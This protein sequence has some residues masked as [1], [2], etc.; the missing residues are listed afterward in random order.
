MRSRKR[1][2][3]PLTLQAQF[4]L[5][6]DNILSFKTDAEQ[7]DAFKASWG[8][9]NG[10]SSASP[11]DDPK[12]VETLATDNRLMLKYVTSRKFLQGD[13]GWKETHQATACYPF[14]TFNED[15][16]AARVQVPPKLC[17]NF[18]CDIAQGWE[19][20][21]R[22]KGVLGFDTVSVAGG[23]KAMYTNVTAEMT[24]TSEKEQSNVVFAIGST[25]IKQVMK[26]SS[27]FTALVNSIE[28]SLVHQGF[29][30]TQEGATDPGL[31]KLALKEAHILFGFSELTHFMYH[32]DKLTMA[33]NTFCSYLTVILNIT[34]SK[35]T[36][37]VAGAEK[38]FEFDDMGVAAVLPSRFWHRSEKAQ[39]G[40]IKLALF[41][42]KTT[43]NA[44]MP[45]SSDSVETEK[46]KKSP[47]DRAISP[48]LKSTPEAKVRIV[49]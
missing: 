38:E 40:T 27:S 39:I 16:M 26:D 11:R 37:M 25:K 6:A 47:S 33:G 21:V 32:R 4:K 46:E 17:C 18:F 24:T 49:N 9:F 20:D 36:F 23:F 13:Y 2:E 14:K 19:T 10:I 29:S 1:K 5:T 41:Y 8:C 7:V 43:H 12:Q 42:V 30:L 35:S 48:Q 45:S 15:I 34:P 44:K 31:E 28:A 22:G 3:S